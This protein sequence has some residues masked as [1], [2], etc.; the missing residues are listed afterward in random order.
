MIV[1]DDAGEETNAVFLKL[2]RLKGFDEPLPDV[3]HLA[4]MNRQ[5]FLR[6]EI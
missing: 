4:F 6:R 1:M 3:V 5:V 2:A